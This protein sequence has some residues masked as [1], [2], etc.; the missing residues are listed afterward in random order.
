MLREGGP[1]VPRALQDSAVGHWLAFLLVLQHCPARL[2]KTP[3]VWRVHRAPDPHPDAMESHLMGSEDGSDP[4]ISLLLL[5]WK[6][7]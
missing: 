5:W 6:S 7:A 4:S 2:R 3:R 1:S